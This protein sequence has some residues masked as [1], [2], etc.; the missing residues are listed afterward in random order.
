[1]NVNYKYLYK[2]DNLIEQILYYISGCLLLVMATG[3]FY[4][5]SMRYLLSEP[6]LWSDEA[7]RAFFLW[8]TY[9]GIIVATKRGQNIRV[10]HFIDK[11]PAFPRVIIETVMHVLVLIMLFSLVWYNMPVIKL[12]LGGKMLS[13]GWSFVWVYLPVSV[14]C[15][16]MFFYQTRLMIKTISIY[17]DKQIEEG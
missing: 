3:I 2:L 13:T 14:G 16:L 4:S 1:M 12:Q 15:T 7:P 10:T 11:V 9:I 17:N 8:L 5:V 6:P